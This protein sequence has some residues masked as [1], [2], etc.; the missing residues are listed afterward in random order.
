MAA[1]IPDVMSIKLVCTNCEKQHSYNIP[2]HELATQAYI[3]LF[4]P[5]CNT[6]FET[7]IVT[8]RA[9]KSRGNKKNQNRTFDIRI[10]NMDES[11]GLISFTN[12]SYD[13]FELRS[14]DQVAFSYEKDKLKIVQ[15]FTISRYWTVNKGGCYL[16]TFVYGKDS[17]E[18]KLLQHFRDTILLQSKILTL[19]VQ[20]YYWLSPKLISILGKNV[21]FQSLV[22]IILMPIIW[23]LKS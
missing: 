23:I 10:I 1:E 16:A 8:I 14:K 11:E 7:H 2:T 3:P 5:E 15:N 9:K 4:C 13:D 18:V 19:L 12:N 6:N 21:L 20:F 17:E 22:R